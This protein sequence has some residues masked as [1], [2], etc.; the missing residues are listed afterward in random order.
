MNKSMGIAV[1]LCSRSHLL[2]SNRL[3][4]EGAAILLPI[5][6]CKGQQVL[7]H[8][9]T[10]QRLLGNRARGAVN[11]DRSGGLRAERLRIGSQ[12]DGPEYIATRAIGDLQTATLEGTQCFP[13][14]S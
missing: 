3:L 9:M 11:P 2:T 8:S 7:D 1:E 5:L 14:V 10:T 4:R 12:D 13:V 6:A